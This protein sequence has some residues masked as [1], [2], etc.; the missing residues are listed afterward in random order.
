[1]DK[2]CGFLRSVRISK[3]FYEDRIVALKPRGTMAHSGILQDYCRSLPFG[4]LVER[5][6]K[7]T[8]TDGIGL[9]SALFV[10]RYDGRPTAQQAGKILPFQNHSGRAAFTSAFLTYS[11]A[12]EPVIQ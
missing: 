3:L 12:L 2:S 9:P 1:M 4:C 8:R 7:L 5:H 11:S 6:R 10:E